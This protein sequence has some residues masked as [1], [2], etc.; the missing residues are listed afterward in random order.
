[1]DY[2]ITVS[3][4]ALREDPDIKR[5]LEAMQLAVN[6]MMHSYFKHPYLSSRFPDNVNALGCLKARVAEYEK[7]AILRC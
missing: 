1:L 5:Y 3:E 7:L 6:R 2:I 4:E